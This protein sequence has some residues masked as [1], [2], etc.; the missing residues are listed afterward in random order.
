VLKQYID[1]HDQFVVT[2]CYR[3]KLLKLFPDKL[4][5]CHPTNM[6]SEVQDLWKVHSYIA[7]YIQDFYEIYNIIKLQLVSLD[8]NLQ[9]KVSKTYVAKL[10]KTIHLTIIIASH[11]L[12]H[13]TIFVLQFTSVN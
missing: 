6:L 12:L 11:S 5:T 9:Q 8:Y 4:H 3:L 7:K 1:D 13:F 2:F 10:C